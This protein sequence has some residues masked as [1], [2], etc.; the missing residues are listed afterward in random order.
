MSHAAARTGPM[1]YGEVN[2]LCI[3]DM[4]PAFE[5]K[6]TPPAKGVTSLMIRNLPKCYTE[7]C[8]LTHI[9]N[10][11]GKGSVDFLYMPWNGKR[12]CNIG[13][14]FVNFVKDTVA[15]EFFL[16]HSCQRWVM[17]D[18][19]R[20]CCRIATAHVQGLAANLVH[21]FRMADSLPQWRRD[22]IV[23]LEGVRVNLTELQPLVE[24]WAK[25]NECGAVPSLTQESKTTAPPKA[26]R[27][28]QRRENRVPGR[29]L[30]SSLCDSGFSDLHF[31]ASSGY[32][33]YDA[34]WDAVR[35]SV[36]LKLGVSYQPSSAPSH[37]AAHDPGL[38]ILFKL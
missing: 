22:P 7:D 31:Q 2:G 4:L 36:T 12:D 6:D 32:G 14:A 17:E 16:K 9:E 18:A 25:V 27:E 28:R 21:F 35:E 20:P 30:S 19:S 10:G 23:F 34:Q 1:T 3:E 29:V 11:F 24:E 38:G 5:G 13:Y 37:V 8:F 26:M 15:F 33:N